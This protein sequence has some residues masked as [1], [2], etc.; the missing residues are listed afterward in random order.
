MQY[1]LGVDNG[2]TAIKAAI[3]DS[4]GQELAVAS[5]KTPVLTP[6][7][8]Y[9]ERDM[10]DL[11]LQ[12]CACIRSVLDSSG[13]SPAQIQAMAVC[14][15]G[16][17]LYLW[18]QDGSPVCHGI[19]STDLRARAYPE[20]WKR[21][22]IHQ[23]LFPQLCQDL[24][25]CQQAALL[26]WLKEHDRAAY[27]RIQWVFSVKDYIRFRLT[28]QAFSEMTDLSGSGLMDVRN[29]RVDPEL[30]RALGIGEIYDK[31]PPLRLSY[32][33]C[34]Q[35]TAQAAA[36]TGLREGTPVAGGMFDIDACA[37]ATDL[38][39]P[40]RICV[41]TGT[42]SINEMISSQPHLDW[43]V[44]MRSRFAMPGYYLL[45]ECSPTG[46]GNLEW[47][48]QH[49]RLPASGSEDPYAQVS[50]L[51]AD[52]SPADCPVYF[53][54]F[55]YGS[56][57]H[58][59]ARGSFV[60]LTSAHSSAHLLRAVYEGV[61]FS[62]KVH[63]D[64]LRQEQGTSLPIR[65]AGGAANSPIWAQIFADVLNAPIQRVQGVRELGALGCAMAAAVA[66]GAYPDYSSAAQSMV[67]IGGQLD[68]NPVMVPIY[69]EKYQ[70]YLAITQALMPVWDRL[71]Q[72]SEETE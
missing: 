5:R 72:S 20:A 51:V 65:M 1:Y 10:E 21:E 23:Q 69:Q 17:G 29:G 7:P 58:S 67:H 71:A 47:I 68:P 4:Q 39:T 48:L 22:G 14:G 42:W 16:K 30:L 55:L 31:I 40:D 56:N 9:Q 15:H 2:G 46:A 57:S 50:Q 60:G 27:D 49:L 70:T 43:P 61:A 66:A 44:A 33:I 53:L 34:G 28:G 37:I 32:D 19:A 12:N 54:P 6:A 3:F 62:H 38:T 26:A 45:E 24:I 52:L 36:L 18:G 64:R 59:F 11:W 25:P 8:D 63:V 41:I 35:V 13:I